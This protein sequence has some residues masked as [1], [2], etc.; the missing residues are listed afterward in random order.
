MTSQSSINFVLLEFQRK[1]GGEYSRAKCN[2]SR[3]RSLIFFQMSRGKKKITLAGQM[4]T[5]PTSWMMA[6][7]IHACTD[8]LV[9]I[10]ICKSSA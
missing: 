2:S 7:Y 4:F 6:P 1:I 9:T 8:K 10:T 3:E 5:N